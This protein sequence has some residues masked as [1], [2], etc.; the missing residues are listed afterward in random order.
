MITIRIRIAHISHYFFITDRIW[1]QRWQHSL[2]TAYYPV[3][4]YQM[5][6]HIAAMMDAGHAMTIKGE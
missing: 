6:V 1:Y 2:V 5:L 4:R 3:T